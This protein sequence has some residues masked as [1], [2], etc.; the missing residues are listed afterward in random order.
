MLSSSELEQHFRHLPVDQLNVVHELR[1]L[2][3]RAAPNATEEIRSQGLVY[4]DAKQGGP[5]VAGI[6]QI[7]VIRGQLRLAFNLGAFLPDP[8]GLLQQ[9]GE[10]LV[11]RFIPLGSFDEIPWRA[12]EDLLVASGQ[13]DIRAYLKNE[14]T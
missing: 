4:Y 11:K 5:V 10:R 8:A 2:I 7:L 13:F 14:K 6:C 1:N 12:I 9:E 3:G